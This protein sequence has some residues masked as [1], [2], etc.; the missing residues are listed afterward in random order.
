MEIAGRVYDTRNYVIMNNR[1][2]NTYKAYMKKCFGHVTR[3]RNR[4]SA[5]ISVI[6]DKCVGLFHFLKRLQ[7]RF[8]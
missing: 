7:F 8:Y 3:L 5:V 1:N 6:W 2:L 4:D